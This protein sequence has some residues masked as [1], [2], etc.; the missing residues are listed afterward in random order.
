MQDAEPVLDEL[1]EEK[2]F[3]DVLKRIMAVDIKEENTPESMDDSKLVS[4]YT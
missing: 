4:K 3:L 2:R 1:M